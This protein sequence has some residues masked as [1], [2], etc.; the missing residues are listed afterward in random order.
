MVELERVLMNEGIK[1]FAEPQ[2]ALLR[3]IAGKR[4]AL[5]DGVPTGNECPSR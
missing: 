4:A 3:L 5:R 1:K 2:K